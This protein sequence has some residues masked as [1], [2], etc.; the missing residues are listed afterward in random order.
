MTSESDFNIVS[1]T[2]EN[3]QL[4][5][6]S[7]VGREIEPSEISPLH[8]VIIDGIRGKAGIGYFGTWSPRIKIVMEEEHPDLGVEF[9][10][11]Y[12]IFDEKDSGLVNWGKQLGKSFRINK[13]VE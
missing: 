3:L 4:E 10:T 5:V 13:I 1:A 2:E 7:Y 9:M 12:Y 11:K 8:P 6:D